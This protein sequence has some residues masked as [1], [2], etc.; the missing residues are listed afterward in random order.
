MDLLHNI[1]NKY[2]SQAAGLDLVIRI[3]DW[4]SDTVLKTVTYLVNFLSQIFF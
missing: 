1:F 4:F 3:A 2:V